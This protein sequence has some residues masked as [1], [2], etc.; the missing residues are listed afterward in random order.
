MEK[1][2]FVDKF[3]RGVG[4]ASIV[5][6]GLS[7]GCIANP[8]VRI[9]DY[10]HGFVTEFGRYKRLLPPGTHK[11][12]P[13]TEK[14]TCREDIVIPEFKCGV[15]I[16]DGKVVMEVGP[17]VYFPIEEDGFELLVYDQVI[18]PELHHGFRFVNNVFKEVLPPGRYNINLFLKNEIKVFPDVSVYE[19]QTGILTRNGVFVKTLEPGNY[20]INPDL[21]EK[22]LV[23]DHSIINEYELGVLTKDGKFVKELEPGR[24]FI[25]TFLK[26]KLYI[27]KHM[28]IHEGAR[29]VKSRDGKFI[30]VLLP[31]IYKVNEFLKESIKIVEETVIQEDH[32][33]LKLVDGKFSE[34]LDSGRHFANPVLNEKIL[35]VSLQVLTKELVPQQIYTKDT[36][37]LTIHS[38][39]VYQIV[40][41]VKAILEVENIDYSIRE[42]I[43]SI[44]QQVM[45]EQTLDYI[46]ENKIH[47]SQTIRERVKAISESWGV[48]VIAIDIKELELDDT[49]K[50]EMTA[51]ATAKREAESKLINASAEVE[52]ARKQREVAEL[53]NTPYSSEMRQFETLKTL[54]QQGAKFIFV[55]RHTS[56]I[57]GPRLE[58]I[59][60]PSLN[61]N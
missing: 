44:T 25:N 21:N 45:S 2:H 56:E 19:N 40:N 28:I 11:I 57:I 55:S 1:P 16:K 54:A 33:G 5:L 22:M 7:L 18:V 61:E 42:Q 8:Y 17:G 60:E 14:V 37:R 13:M 4:K 32:K 3:K 27:F 20:A 58:K 39:L 31:G 59:L 29:G 30:E 38:I 26:E 41:P 34:I 23:Y 10:H 24:Y 9:K 53:L 43:K 49:I 46:M 35:P 50:K 6:Y 15:L 51:S 12:N 48:K 36:T 52:I 47:L